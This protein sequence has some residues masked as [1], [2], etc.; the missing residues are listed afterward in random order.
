MIAPVTIHDED[1][2]KPMI[3]KIKSD[4]FNDAGECL[5][6]KGYSPWKVHSVRMISVHD[7]WRYEHLAL[8]TRGCSSADLGND[9]AVGV[10]RQVVSMILDGAD[11]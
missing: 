6:V 2:S 5:P 9:Q 11:R 8:A 7:G 3:G 1:L 10:E 4:L